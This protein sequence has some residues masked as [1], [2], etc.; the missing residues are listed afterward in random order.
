M[1]L[2][3]QQKYRSLFT[4]MAMAVMIMVSSCKK[5]VEVNAPVT[6]LTGTSV[7]DSD[8]N[9]IS[10]LTG[11]YS[12]M[13]AT[14]PVSGYNLSLYLGLS[15]D[16][17]SLFNTS[18][19][20]FAGYYTNNLS[21]S[22]TGTETWTSFYNL[23]YTTNAAIAG[24][25]SSTSLTP[26][27]KQQLLGEAYFVR[28]FL[29]FY[30]TNLYGE[31]PLITSTNYTVNAVA[32]RSPQTMVYKQITSDLVNAQN[33]L[34]PNYLDGTVL[35]TTTDRF[36]P[37][38]WAAY[39]L[40][41]R[42]Y[43]YMGDWKDAA[44][45]A[46]TVISNTGIFNLSTLNNTFLRASLGN[47]EAIWQL[48]VVYSIV[49]DAG[50]FI[51]PSTGPGPNSLVYLSNNL[52]NSFEPGDQR[53]ANWVDS[54]ITGGTT[55][56]YPYKYKVNTPQT[57]PPESTTV[58]RL[59]ELYLI[60]AEAETYG[61]GNGVSG[62]VADLNTIRNRAG[63]PNYSGAAIQGQVLTAIYHERQVEFFSEWGHRWLDLKRTGLVN[64]VMPAVDTQKGGTWS[65]YKQLYPILLTDIKADPNLSQ[66]S[67]Y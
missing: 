48:Q 7:Y 57:P 25:N 32:S 26:A 19:P 41:A 28:A 55:Y 51:L 46:T 35:T 56:Y 45:Q 15:A 59:A 58:L 40:L 30:L 11:I 60:R 6:S 39:A 33:L 14:V 38:K 49:S 1:K 66:N 3:T 54:V 63:L 20:T 65:P 67:G 8:D 61:V 62:A 53:K 36:R 10:V 16:E 44:A 52:V 2:N 43:L 18:N 22:A 24:L 5:L 29:Y 34:S 23:I 13:S 37:T 27:V 64:T 50:I 47:D 42:V 12:A 21:S 4:I 31:V 9:A 17:Y